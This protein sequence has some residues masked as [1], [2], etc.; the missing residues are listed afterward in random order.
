M[1]ESK[2]YATHFWPIHLVQV[3]TAGPTRSVDVEGQWDG[4]DIMTKLSFNT[5][6]IA[7]NFM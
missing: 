4:T 7:G 6:S 5:Q 3:T 1:R 2:T